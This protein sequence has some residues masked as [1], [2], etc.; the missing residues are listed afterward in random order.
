MI[1]GVFTMTR[2]GSLSECEIPASC[3]HECFFFLYICTLVCF[4]FLFVHKLTSFWLNVKSLCVIS[5][6]VRRG[7]PTFIR[8]VEC[9]PRCTRIMTL[10]PL[11]P[12]KLSSAI[13]VADL[14]CCSLTSHIAGRELSKLVNAFSLACVQCRNKLM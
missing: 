13:V 1:F 2:S 5:C 4:N 7:K 10:N 9:D 11:L 14:F 12:M 3:K 8:I 6:G